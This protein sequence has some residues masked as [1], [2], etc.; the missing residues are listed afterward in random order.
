MVEHLSVE[1]LNEA[2][3][4]LEENGWLQRPAYCFVKGNVE[5][6]FDTSNY[7]EVYQTSS[8]ERIQEGRVNCLDDLKS[9]LAK[10][11]GM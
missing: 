1:N 2:F 8:G 5:L 3:R 10:V 4:F 11:S 6:V 7:V 9:L